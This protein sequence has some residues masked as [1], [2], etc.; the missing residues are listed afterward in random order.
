MDY[1]VSHFIP[2]QS[3]AHNKRERTSSLSSVQREW[4]EGR[5]QL[6]KMP[7]VKQEGRDELQALGPICSE[8][9]SDLMKMRSAVF[10]WTA[11]TTAMKTDLHLTL[12]RPGMKS[13]LLFTPQA[14]SD[15]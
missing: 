9:T 13:A 11:M 12:T 15:P 4:Q 5:L 14:S 6:G 3:T 1:S 2:S 8:W 10:L 7:L